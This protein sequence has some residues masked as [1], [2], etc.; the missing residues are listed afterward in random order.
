M[1]DVD[2]KLFD[3]RRPVSERQFPVTSQRN[4]RRYPKCHSV[5]RRDVA[6]RLCG[7]LRYCRHMDDIRSVLLLTNHWAVAEKFN[8][9]AW[10]TQLFEQHQDNK[11]LYLYLQQL[12]HLARYE[13]N[14]PDSYPTE[15]LTDYHMEEVQER[16]DRIMNMHKR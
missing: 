2:A 7:P 1:K 11:E 9:W 8:T 3:L 4:T 5:P 12:E 14:V 16:T 6:D 13:N 15:G 10:W